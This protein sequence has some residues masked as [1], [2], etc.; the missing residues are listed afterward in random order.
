MRYMLLALT[1]ISGCTTVTP[2]V[3]VPIQPRS[4]SLGW[5]VGVTNAPFTTEEWA[6]LGGRG[7]LWRV[8]IGQAAD[9]VAR[10]E[11]LHLLAVAEDD[12]S[13][14]ALLPYVG[15]AQVFEM[16]NEPNW[17]QDPES[18]NAWYKRTIPRLRDAGFAGTICTAG[19]ANLNDDTL[20]WL[21][22]S[23]AGLPSD[24]CIA[25]HGYD[26]FQ[27]AVRQAQIGK[28]LAIIGTHPH[29]MTESGYEETRTNEDQVATQVA[30]DIVDVKASG[31]LL[32]NFYQMHDDPRPTEAKYGLVALDRHWRSV[33]QVLIGALP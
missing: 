7:F 5:R 10:G 1:F 33:M 19:I 21:T 11:P 13:V 2:I 25:W 16:G 22:P 12:D 3:P 17:A 27:S 4:F 23:I 26:G 9:V 31:A 8:E 28:L 20:A 29:M 15:A 14:T 24:I 18:G 32:Y 6:H 30:Q